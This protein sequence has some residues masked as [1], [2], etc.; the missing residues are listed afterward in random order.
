[1]LI[2]RY[3]LGNP[4]REDQTTTCGSTDP[5][6]GLTRMLRS[7]LNC[8][9]NFSERFWIF[10]WDRKA[11]DGDQV[12]M[13][14]SFQDVAVFLLLLL[15]LDSAVLDPGITSTAVWNRLQQEFR[16][17]YAG[18][19]DIRCKIALRITPVDPPTYASTFIIVMEA[20]RVALLWWP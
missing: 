19:M 12:D 6:T 17:Y 5:S 9:R 16:S 4:E 3:Y 2:F 14:F 18:K 8:T 15:L 13:R 20:T 10:M 11:N 1:M 7:Y